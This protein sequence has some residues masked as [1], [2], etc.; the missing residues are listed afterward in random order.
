MSTPTASPPLT[1]H[2]LERAL[3]TLTEVPSR[4]IEPTRLLQ[5]LFTIWQH[6]YQTR[7][8]QTETICRK[9]GLRQNPPQPTDPPF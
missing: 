6:G 2:D 7:L 5:A 3:T 1:L 8:D 4:P 9:C